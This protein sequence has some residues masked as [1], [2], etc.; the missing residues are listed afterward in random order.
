MKSIVKIFQEKEVR[1]T[2]IDGEIYFCASDVGRVLELSAIYHQVATFEKGVHTVQALTN[3]GYQDVLFINEPNLYRLIFK[4]RKE[5]AK[6]FQDW[7]FEEVIPSIRKTG[8]Y[9]IP[10]QLKK[11][12]VE[13]RNRMTD[14]WQE[15]GVKGLEFGK[16]TLEEYSILNFPKDRRKEFMTNEEIRILEALESLESIN[17]HYNPVEGFIECKESLQKTGSIVRYIKEGSR[18]ANIG[19]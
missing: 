9:S 10:D 18:N 1:V 14:A 15:C 11:K 5:N 19:Q 17:L 3:G 6:A 2:Q 7:I 12:S 4:S 13:S 8:K 16:L